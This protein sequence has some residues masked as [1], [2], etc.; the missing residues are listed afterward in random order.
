[1]SVAGLGTQSPTKASPVCGPQQACSPPPPLKSGT[2]AVSAPELLRRCFGLTSDPALV[3]SETELLKFSPSP[4]PPTVS[5]S[6]DWLL[7]LDK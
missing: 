3:P 2:R 1:M 4:P 6:T 5:P 7:L